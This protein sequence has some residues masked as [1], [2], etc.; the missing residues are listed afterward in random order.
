MV[1][2]GKRPCFRC[3]GGGAPCPLWTTV[4]QVITSGYSDYA[5]RF[6]Y[7]WKRR[8]NVSVT[9][10]VWEWRRTECCVGSL[11]VTRWPSSVSLSLACCLLWSNWIWIEISKWYPNNCVLGSWVTLF[12]KCRRK[13]HYYY[14]YYYYYY[15]S[16]V[17]CREG[18]KNETYGKSLYE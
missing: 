1:S 4:V 10:C 14:Y 3:W 2:T 9:W 6:Q 12:S 16:E 5:I 17:Q 11:I 15:C 8:T 7:R 13:C 18:G